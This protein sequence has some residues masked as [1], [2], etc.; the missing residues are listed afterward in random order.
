MRLTFLKGG[1]REKANRSIVSDFEII[2]GRILIKSTFNGTSP[3]RSQTKLFFYGQRSN[4]ERSC[5]FLSL[6]WQLT[7]LLR[8]HHNRI[9]KK[10][11]PTIIVSFS[12]FT[13]LAF[14]ASLHHL[15][16]DLQHLILLCCFPQSL[17][18]VG[19]L[20]CWWASAWNENYFRFEHERKKLK[21]RISEG[22]GRKNRS[23]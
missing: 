5:F 1:R 8:N 3:N 6:A 14:L 11:G 10:L 13:S 12:S 16:N 20:A 4:R 15:D 22:P 21:T 23:F 19:R 18:A 9:W 2:F 7:I 17:L